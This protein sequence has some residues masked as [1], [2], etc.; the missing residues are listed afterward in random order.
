MTQSFMNA[1]LIARAV[2]KVR[3]G[4]RISRHST[5]HSPLIALE[6][7]RR[8][9]FVLETLQPSLLSQGHLDNTEFTRR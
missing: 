9:I 7:L 3:G 5:G 8:L 6:W 4:F 2:G 1:I